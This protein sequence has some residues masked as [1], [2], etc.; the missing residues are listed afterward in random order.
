MTKPYPK[1]LLTLLISL[2]FISRSYCQSNSKKLIDIKHKLELYQYKKVC[3]EIETI[4]EASLSKADK[5][6][7][8]YLK[9]ECFL[10]NSRINQA[11]Q[12]YLK[13]KNI[14]ISLDSIDKA[15][16]INLDIYNL[17]TAQEN[18]SSIYKKYLDEYIAH[19]HKTN[20]TVRLARSIKALGEI[21]YDNGKPKESLAYFKKAL[22]LFQ[23]ANER[24]KASAVYFNIAT[25]YNEQLH[26]YDSALYYLNKQ[27]P[28][29]KT[30]GVVDDL[31]Y[32]YVD[33]AA[34]YYYLKNH[35]KAIEY[36]KL[37]DNL[38]L[39]TS[40]S[41]TSQYVN[42]FLYKNYD[43]LGDYTNAYKYLHLSK[44]YSD[45]INIVEQNIA[46]NDIHTKYQTKEKELENT[47]LKSEVKTSKILIYSIIILL[48]AIIAI[49]ALIIKNSRRREKISKQEKLIEQQKFEK[50]MK[51]YEL[52]SIDMI[53]EGQDKERQRIAN[54]LH[55]NLGSMLATLKLNFE[56]LRLRKKELREEENKL[57]ERTDELIE[58]A[59]QKVRR[60]AHAK[61]AGVFA[62][63]GLIPAIQKLAEK[64]SIPGKIQLQVI[65]FGF[66]DRLENSLEIAIFRTVQEL[67]TNIIKHSQ[68]TEATIHL[69]DHGDSINIMI[70]D[71]G[72]GFD[73][74]K[75]NLDDADGMG[76]A[77]ITKK[78]N[79][80]GGSVE[81][82]STPGKGTTIIIDIPVDND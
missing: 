62:S 13:S 27:L 59:Y 47:L 46:I 10:S 55:D 69:T 64:I 32:N 7:Y 8:Y 43:A 16:D 30:Y 26:K 65:P 6:L 39:N 19:A 33:Q 37:A 25:I 12:Y 73:S 58:E 45:S 31:W 67:S 20:D 17:I 71:N 40:E 52:N 48:I 74:S 50:A 21:A 23:K 76:L 49:A 53:L 3:P 77:N 66:A 28:E 56:N 68:A 22:D 57:Y 51:E 5:A 15:M 80:L 36:L 61:N 11:Y 34:S 42:E 82:D 38:P 35:R 9:A 60:I 54:D 81:I 63:E 70:E 18:Y 1:L 44:K 41:K 14:Y 79:Q 78:I 75:I 24:E 29:I 72:V 4:K 2:L